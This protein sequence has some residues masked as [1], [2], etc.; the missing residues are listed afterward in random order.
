VPR[1]S[2]LDT[3]P[4]EGAPELARK[5]L[6][7]SG[8]EGSTQTRPLV[9][10]YFRHPSARKIAEWL[11]SQWKKNLDLEVKLEEVSQGTYWQSLQSHPSP[12]FMGIK[13]SAYPDP[14]IFFRAYAEPNVLNAGQWTDEAYT[15]QVQQASLSADPDKRRKIYIQLSR[16]LLIEKPALIPLLLK[17]SA[18]LIKPFVEG[19]E[20]NA[21]GGLDLSRLSYD[22]G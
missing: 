8:A 13:T 5:L 4:L 17:S 19:V 16:K 7:E 12:L 14:D 21:L 1:D 18:H 6:K 15:E 2:F 20:F 3:S 10:R 22:R 11:Q 9:F